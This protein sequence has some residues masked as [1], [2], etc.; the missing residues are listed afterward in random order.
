MNAYS[1][2][3]YELNE[4]WLQKADI[5]AW[6]HFKKKE[7]NPELNG[8]FR[9]VFFCFLEPISFF[10]QILEEAVCFLKISD[11]SALQ[12]QVVV[13]LL[14]TYDCIPIANKCF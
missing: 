12:T 7:G 13:F 4:P 1:L 2:S 8:S 5:T 6:T 14:P 9:L 11:L 3:I 10:C